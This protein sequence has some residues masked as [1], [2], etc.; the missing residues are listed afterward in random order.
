[1]SWSKQCLVRMATSRDPGYG[2]GPAERASSLAVL[3]TELCPPKIH[4]LKPSPSMWLH[5]ERRRLSL[6]H[7]LSL[8]PSLTYEDKWEGS[9]LQARKR[10]LIRNWI[11][12]HLDLGLQAWR[13]VRKETPVA[14]VTQSVVF[15]EGSLSWPIQAAKLQFASEVW[16]ERIIS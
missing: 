3:W 5:L 11:G 15:C 9:H 16:H 4:M 6:A 14:L 13:T 10:A 12:W 2:K 1:M 8:S 7:S